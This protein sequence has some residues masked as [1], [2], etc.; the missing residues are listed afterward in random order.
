MSLKPQDASGYIPNE[1]EIAWMGL[2][3]ADILEGA[4]WIEF[5]DAWKAFA[6]EHYILATWNQ[7]TRRLFEE[8]FPPPQPS[9]QLKRIYCNVLGDACGPLSQI[10]EDKDLKALNLPVLGRSQPRLSQAT[11][12]S[13]WLSQYAKN[14]EE[15]LKSQEGSESDPE[16]AQH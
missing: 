4:S 8:R 9:I 3:P 16:V 11:A 12:L 14:Q 1:E 10:V 6:G 2:K 7:I 5:V 15:R 13:H